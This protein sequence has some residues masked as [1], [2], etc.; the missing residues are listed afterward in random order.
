MR[1]TLLIA[2]EAAWELNPVRLEG[3]M[4]KRLDE[5]EDKCY[6]KSKFKKSVEQVSNGISRT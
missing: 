6:N 2:L 5:N 1:D 4:W 3:K